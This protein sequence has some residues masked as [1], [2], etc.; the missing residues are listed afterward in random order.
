MGSPADTVRGARLR[1]HGAPLV[2]EEVALPAPGPREV[3]VEL[4]YAGVNPIDFYIAQGAVAPDAPLP[5]TLGGEGAGSANGRPVLVAG[6]GLGA[7][8]DGT[9]AQAAV[10]PEAALL[11]IP[12]GVAVQDAAAMGI[13]GLT[14]L[15]A[16]R[17]LGQVSGEDRVLVLGASGGV[18]SMIVPLA[19]ATGAIVWGQ[20]GSEAKTA[21]ILEQGADRAVVAGPEELAAQMAEYQPTVVFDVLGGGFMAP[22]VETVAV[23]GRIVSLG[24]SAGAEVAFNLRL[25]YRKMVTLLGYGGTQLTR[26][27]RRPGLEQALQ[28]VA[29]GSLRVRIDSVMALD[30]VND[31]FARINRRGV[32]G[33]L[34][35]DLS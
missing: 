8:R 32:Q 23:R 13:A 1:R 4:G 7:G 30:E 18:G 26:A 34:L 5:R 29:D 10:V 2:V 20:T 11:P 15:N 21:G 3:R 25:L 12:D 19:K 22:V 16:V 27:E 6:E 24:V 9:W 28:A 35:L 31:A 14:A 33:K 17:E